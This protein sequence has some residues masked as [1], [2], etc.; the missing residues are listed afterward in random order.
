[1]DFNNFNPPDPEQLF[2]AMDRLKDAFAAAADNSTG[3]AKPAFTKLSDSF[4]RLTGVAGTLDLGGLTQGGMPDLGA[5]M[6]AVGAFKGFHSAFNEVQTLARTDA[7]AAATFAELTAAVKAEGQN[8]GGGL[9]GGLGGIG[10]L[11]DIFGKPG[12]APEAEETPAP[13]PR[14]PKKP[15]GGDFKL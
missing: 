12:D 8:L 15:K 1:M 14:K 6:Q 3:A 7:A 4:N 13:K 5:L 11:D 10:G 9:L 2:Q